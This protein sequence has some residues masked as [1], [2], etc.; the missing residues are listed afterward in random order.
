MS[1]PVL[2]L[3]A[4]LIGY[5]RG[6][7][8]LETWLGDPVRV[9]DQLPQAVA[10]PYVTFGRVTAQA[11][12]GLGGEVIEQT[13]NLLCVSRHAGTEEVKAMAGAVRD[14][15]DGAEVTVAGQ[16]LVSLRVVFVDVFRAADNRTI[17][18]LVRLR[19]VSEAA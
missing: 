19:A 17:Y 6:Q 2:E 16:H 13:L 18:G 1:D 9:Y 12:G 4:A 8:V 11:I 3:Q 7:G 10:Y 14:L 5:L 15:L